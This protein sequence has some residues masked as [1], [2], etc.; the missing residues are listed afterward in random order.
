M[1]SWFLRRRAAL[2]PTDGA[3]GSAYREGRIDD[4]VRPTATAAPRERVVAVTRPRRRGGFVV[5]LIVL[6]VVVFGC[7]MLYLAA[8]NGSF[9]RGGA[10]V[11]QSISQAGAPI[12]N[13]EDRAGGALESAG[14]HLK[15]DAGPAAP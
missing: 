9:S 3:E 8:Q 5:S 12:R 11:D 10:V 1:K 4:N 15:R 14:R 2:R 7:V 13:A 6:A